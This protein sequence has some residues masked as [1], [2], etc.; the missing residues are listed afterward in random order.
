MD[1][2]VLTTRYSW[3]HAWTKR[4][5]KGKV[6]RVVEKPTRGLFLKQLL[7]ASVL[8][9]LCPFFFHHFVHLWW[10]PF[11]FIFQL[12]YE[13]A[14]SFLCLNLCRLCEFYTICVYIH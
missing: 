6:T 5:V 12:E 1:I 8:E 11:L 3:R 2:P 14:P 10:L 9:L 7:L 4:L 13:C